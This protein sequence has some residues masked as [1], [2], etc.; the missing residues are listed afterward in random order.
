MPCDQ[1]EE[2]H[3]PAEGG[4]LGHGDQLRASVYQPTIAQKS[5][6]RS[7]EK[8]H[9]GRSDVAIAG[10]AGEEQTVCAS[11]TP[12]RA[13]P[14]PNGQIATPCGIAGTGKGK[15][16]AATAQVDGANA[17]H[18]QG[19]QRLAESSRYEGSAPSRRCLL[20]AITF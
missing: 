7:A 3:S 18:C 17:S 11:S 8:L 14:V 5:G 20:F 13:G 4:W 2:D 1:A 6:A 19:T 9:V 15:V 10:V 12:N 16:G